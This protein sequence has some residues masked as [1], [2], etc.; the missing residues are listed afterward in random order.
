MNSSAVIQYASQAASHSS[1]AS[2][3]SWSPRYT[4]GPPERLASPSDHPHWMSGSATSGRA[5][6]LPLAHST[7]RRRSRSTSSSDTPALPPQPH[8]FERVLAL[9][10][11][12]DANHGAAPERPDL[13]VA[14]CDWCPALRTGRVLMHAHDHAVSGG[15]EL[16]ADDR[17][18]VEVGEEVLAHVARDL[19]RSAVRPGIRELGTQDEQ[20]GGVVELGAG[21]EV[22]VRPLLVDGA[23]GLDAALRHRSL[24]PGAAA[25]TGRTAAADRLRAAPRGT[26]GRGGS[27]TVRRRSP[28]R[29]G[30]SA[31]TGARRARCPG[32]R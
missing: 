14:H 21:A 10:D 24:R 27:P 16:L 13:V 30:P 28:G 2:P 23:N 29:A 19:L 9:T 20:H 6:R 5:Q 1:V 11:A 15:E 8:G 4:R 17:Q 7:Y 26:G 31:G 25:R 18:A 22:P 12:L 3:I 32:C